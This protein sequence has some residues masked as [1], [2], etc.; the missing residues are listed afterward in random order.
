MTTDREWTGIVENGT[1]RLDS[2]DA[3]P[4]GT[5]V[6]VR[7]IAKRTANKGRKSKNPGNA[8]SGRK[9]VASAALLKFSGCVRDLPRDASLNIDH[10][11]YGATKRR[12]PRSTKRKR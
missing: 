1:I 4:E 12:L 6:S 8:K 9:I 2:D 7:A 10:Y 5:R 11:L 3:L